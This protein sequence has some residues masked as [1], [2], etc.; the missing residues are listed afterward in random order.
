M[1]SN[2]D[3][4]NV[5]HLLLKIFLSRALVAILAGRAESFDSIL[6]CGFIAIK[7]SFFFILISKIFI[8]NV[9]FPIQIFPIK[10]IRFRLYVLAMC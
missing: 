9:D 4:Y 2:L 7:F 1:I 8:N 3:Q 10:N 6:F 5:V